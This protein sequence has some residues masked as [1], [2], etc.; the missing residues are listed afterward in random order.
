MK[1]IH[2]MQDGTMKESIDGVVIKNQD[3][4]AIL[5][6]IQKQRKGVHTK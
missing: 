4:Y 2:I 5:N 6:A 3:F 1:I